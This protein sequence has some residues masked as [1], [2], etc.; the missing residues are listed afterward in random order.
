MVGETIKARQ[1]WQSRSAILT[2]TFPGER[3][4]I[5]FQQRKRQPV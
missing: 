1:Q 5:D 3:P 4:H 2:V